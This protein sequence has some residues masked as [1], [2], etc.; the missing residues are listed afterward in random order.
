MG[1]GFSEFDSPASAGSLHDGDKEG[2]V[3]GGEVPQNIP[4]KRDATCDQAVANDSLLVAV[5]ETWLHDGIFDA[6]VSHDFPGYHILR[7]DQSRKKF[8][9]VPQAASL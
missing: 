2:A 3:G 8:P 1:P 5:T 7:C 9:S 4:D 6:E